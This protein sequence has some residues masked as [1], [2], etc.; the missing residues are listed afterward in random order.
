[1]KEETLE[2]GYA[3]I[4][5]MCTFRDHELVSGKIHDMDGEP[6]PEPDMSDEAASDP[7]TDSD[8]SEE[9]CVC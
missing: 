2:R 5:V 3:C 1:M 8:A 4:L 7:E 6:D 9:A